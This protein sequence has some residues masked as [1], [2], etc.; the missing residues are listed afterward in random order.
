MVGNFKL[1]KDISSAVMYENRESS[2]KQLKAKDITTETYEEK[3]TNNK[4][5]ISLSD[6]EFGKY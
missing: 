2:Y 3:D 4:P 5:R 6:K 1:K